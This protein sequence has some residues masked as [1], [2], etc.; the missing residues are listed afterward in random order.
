[1]LPRHAWLVA[2]RHVTSMGGSD[3]WAGFVGR[4]W[5]V[6]QVFAAI[7]AMFAAHW[8]FWRLLSN[9]AWLNGWPFPTAHS[10]VQGWLQAGRHVCCSGEQAA[11]VVLGC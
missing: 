8:A 6:T 9:L 11:W 3:T 1:M 5:S 10:Q 7:D 4:Q 2:Q